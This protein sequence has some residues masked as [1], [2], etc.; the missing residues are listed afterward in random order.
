MK[1]YLAAAWSRR[2]EIEVVAE[3][4]KALGI[5][6]TSRWLQEEKNMQQAIGK[7]LSAPSD[8]FLRER[9]YTDLEDVDAADAIV[10]FS[11]DLSQ[12]IVPSHLASGAR[13]FEFGYAKAK[14]K[15]LF[16]VGG[17]QNVFDRLQEVIHVKDVDE[18]CAVL[19]QS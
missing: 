11:D 19:A 7:N 5:E 2:Y 6:I 14:G 13:M 18:L 17:K 16:V 8:R 15:T 10:R 1:I 12:S 3:R 4:L 9:A